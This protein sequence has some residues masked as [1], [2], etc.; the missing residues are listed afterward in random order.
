MIHDNRFGFPILWDL[1]RDYYFVLKLLCIAL[2]SISNSFAQ[3]E[4]D[5]KEKKT[6]GIP[7]PKYVITEVQTGLPDISTLIQFEDINA[8]G[9]SNTSSPIQSQPVSKTSSKPATPA[10]K[11][12]AAES[13]LGS[14]PIPAMNPSG[15][16]NHSIVVLKRS[17]HAVQK[18]SNIT[19]ESIL[20][21][22]G[23]QLA[24]CT[25]CGQLGDPGS[26][27]FGYCATGRCTPG[28]AMCYPY[29]GDSLFQ[30]MSS[31]IYQ[32]LSCPDPCYEPVWNPLANAGLMDSPRPQTMMRLRYDH[33]SNV[34]TP[35]RAGFFWA[36]G[37]GKGLGPKPLRLAQNTP[38]MKPPVPQPIFVN[39]DE[40]IYSMEA[41]AAGKMSFFMNFSYRNFNSNQT[42]DGASGFGDMSLGTKS[43]LFDSE[44]FL[45]T[46]Q[47][48]TY[49]PIG[50]ASKGLG[51][52]TV[53]FEPSLLMALKLSER[54][55]LQGQIGEWIPLSIG[56]N[57]FGSIL[58]TKFSLNHELVEIIPNVPLIGFIEMDSWSFQGGRYTQLFYTQQKQISAISKPGNYETYFNIGPGAR[59]AFSNKIDVGAGLLMGLGSQSWGNPIFTFDFRW[60]Y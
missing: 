6:T 2:T 23:V 4:L 8:I 57:Y 31:L 55:Y 24:G 56:S 37:S 36:D 58:N 17:D 28:R 43:V 20:M 16:P 13:P 45:M 1:K 9:N 19:P 26:L 59:I 11:I 54:T 48:K 60:M 10:S 18:A 46:F 41:G 15:Q 53:R 29:V 33:Y 27:D 44:L 25:R 52:G 50:S 14:I 3:T 21:D 35:D 34:T 12:S 51:L 5:I 40:A 38:G 42:Y 47:F 32:C 7:S 39:F 49:I 30:R 22:P